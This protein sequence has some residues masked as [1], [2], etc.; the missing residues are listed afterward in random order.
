M[1]KKISE[2][3]I[4][5]KRRLGVSKRAFMLRAKAEELGLGSKKYS[6]SEAVEVVKTLADD[7]AFKVKFDQTLDVVFKLGVDPRKD[8]VRGAVN[9]VHGLGKPVRVAVF[10]K[11][12]HQKEASAAG[13]DL[14]G[15][16]DLVEQVQQGII[17]F[18]K[19]VATPDMMMTLGKVAKVLGPKGLMPNPKLGT[20]TTNVADAVKA[21]K[22]GQITY[23]LEKAGLVHAAIG[24]TS[25]E[26][27]KI[28]D[29]FKTLYDAILK[30]KPAGSKGTYVQKLYFTT[31]MGVAVEV[32]LTTV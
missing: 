15:G 23:K 29:N 22:S 17:N 18:D 14:V 1:S 21:I 3:V 24:K 5:A 25:F 26:V 4:K 10:C 16:D 11:G 28:V 27:S 6:L 31:T 9:A 13:A 2:Q 8:T 30:A 32:D 20:V 12:D 7:P 19:A